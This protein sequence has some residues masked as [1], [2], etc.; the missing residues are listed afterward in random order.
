MA[1]WF[2]MAIV[3]C[4][5]SPGCFFG[6]AR[7]DVIHKLESRRFAALS[8]AR[9]A[10]AADQIEE[11][12]TIRSPE[13]RGASAN[14]IGAKGAGAASILPRLI[15]LTAGSDSASNRNVVRLSSSAATIQSIEA[16]TARVGMIAAEMA[17]PESQRRS[18]RHRT[19]SMPPST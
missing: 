8:A 17:L 13:P 7:P 10:I 14:A 3:T 11:P 6:R 5:S 9:R 1:V 15:G 4:A 12:S 18:A 16:S 2:D 19:A